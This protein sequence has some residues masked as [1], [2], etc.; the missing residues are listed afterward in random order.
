[1]LGRILRLA[2]GLKYKLLFNLFWGHWRAQSKHYSKRY[3]W[4]KKGLLNSPR[5]NKA[6]SK[7][8]HNFTFFGGRGGA[9]WGQ[10]NVE[11]LYQFHVLSFLELWSP[12][13][14]V[15]WFPSLRNSN[16]IKKTIEASFIHH[17]PQRICL[18]RMSSK[19]SGLLYHI[20]GNAHVSSVP[21]PNKNDLWNH[22]ITIKGIFFSHQKRMNAFSCGSPG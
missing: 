22:G 20:S 6:A 3:S 1:M 14:W 2:F 9:W 8:Y 17:Q 7:L 10:C 12:T 15:A 21:E 19:C 4:E 16:R 13:S 18:N 11:R 5:L